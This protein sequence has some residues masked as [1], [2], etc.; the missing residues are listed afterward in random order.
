MD[1]PT[2]RRARYSRIAR[3]VATGFVLMG[4]SGCCCCV[5][6]IAE[7]T[8]REYVATRELP[9]RAEVAEAL[10]RRP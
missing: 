1:T 3:L 2:V 7:E 6:P 10:S 5:V 9:D 8:G 4:L